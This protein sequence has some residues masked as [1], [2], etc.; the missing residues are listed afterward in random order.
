MSTIRFAQ[1]NFTSTVLRQFHS[2]G[3]TGRLTG[4]A[5]IFIIVSKSVVYD[6]GDESARRNSFV[7][8]VLRRKQSTLGVT[9]GAVRGECASTTISPME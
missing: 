9:F 8:L 3:S 7:A 2:W 4:H 5:L 6:G 1:S